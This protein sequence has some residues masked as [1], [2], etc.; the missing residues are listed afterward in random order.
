MGVRSGLKRINLSNNR[1]LRTA[2]NRISKIKCFTIFFYRSVFFFFLEDYSVQV[3]RLIH[4]VVNQLSN[5]F[6]S[7]LCQCQFSKHTILLIFFT[8]T[9]KLFSTRIPFIMN[10]YI[11]SCRKIH[12]NKVSIRLPKQIQLDS[13]RVPKGINHK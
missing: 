10:N 12:E 7:G 2:D 6:K 13:N 9:R 8:K 1:S 4:F 11:T 5:K 3:F